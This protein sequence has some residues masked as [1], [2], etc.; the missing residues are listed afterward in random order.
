MKKTLSFG[1]SLLIILSLF[2]AALPLGANAADGMY[3]ENGFVYEIIGI[4][5]QKC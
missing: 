3:S 4:A 5:F 1:L 2:T